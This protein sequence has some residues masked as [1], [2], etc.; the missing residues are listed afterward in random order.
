VVLGL[1]FWAGNLLLFQDSNS[2]YR[3][4]TFGLCQIIGLLTA[5]ALAQISTIKPMKVSIDT[6]TLTPSGLGIEK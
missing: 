6:Q 1:G 3:R 2:M 4:A 5:G